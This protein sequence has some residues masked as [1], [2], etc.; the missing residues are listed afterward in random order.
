LS[1]IETSADV[2]DTTNVDAAGAVMNTDT[3]TSA[4]NFVVDEDNM[5]SNSD[6]KV[7]TQQSVKAYVDANSG[8]GGSGEAN[9]NAFSTIAVSGQSNVAADSTTDTLNIAAGTNVTITTDPSTD[10]VTITSTDTNTTY[11]VG[12]GGLTQNNFTDALK[13]KL[14]GISANAN[15]GLTDIVSDTTP[16]LGGNLDVQAFEINT[17]TTNGNIKLTANGTG[18]VEVKGNTNAGTIQFNCESNSHGVKLQSPAHSAAQ[19][20][21]LILPDNQVAADKFLKVKSISGSGAT[22][23]GQ[24]EFADASGGSSIGGDTGVDFNDNINVRFGASNDGV[25]SYISSDDAFTISSADGADIK[26]DSD[27]DLTIECD[28]DMK[29]ISGDSIQLRHGSSASS[30]AMIICNDDSSVQL[31]HNNSLKIQTESTGASITGNLNVSSDI[32]DSSGYHGSSAAEIFDGRAKV[33]INFDG[34]G[35]ISIRGSIGVSSI[36]DTNTGKYVVTFSSSFSN[37]NYV[38]LATV[39]NDSSSSAI[40]SVE[41][42]EPTT[43]D[44]ELFVEDVDS[45]FTDEDY[46]YVVIF[47]QE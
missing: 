12:D 27:D 16:Q 45:A 40:G 5:S 35:T 21:T 42:I 28:D 7:P 22:A 9:Q 1:G 8:G 25:I 14:D 13:T 26:I 20:Y 44:L 37:I 24:L 43:A 18:F 41:I 34:T 17:A 39:G 2:T 38:A 6:T 30:E 19:S 10:T 4:M 3:S 46:V 11:S 23:V 36:S 32:T 15:V 29:I 31:Y 47:A 33:Y